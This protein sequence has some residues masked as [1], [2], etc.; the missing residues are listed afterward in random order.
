[1]KERDD[2]VSATHQTPVV[3][4]KAE[5]PTL[6]PNG[7]AGTEPGPSLNFSVK[8]TSCS[9]SPDFDSDHPS[10]QLLV[11]SVHDKEVDGKVGKMVWDI[12]TIVI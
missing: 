12:V 7:M 8:T 5:P 1:M 4:R 9:G 11:D 3:K 6:D 10:F 2:V